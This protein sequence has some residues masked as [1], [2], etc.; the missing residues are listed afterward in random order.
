MANKIADNVTE[1]L[2]NGDLDFAADTIQILLV[3]ASFSWDP[4]TD[5]FVSDIATLGELTGAGYERKTLASKTVT[6]SAGY[7]TF[8]AASPV[9]ASIAS[10][11]TIH[12]AVVYKFDT[13][14]DASPIIAFLDVTNTPTNGQQVTFDFAATGILKLARKSGS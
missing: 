3:D 14:D 9:W 1:L 11:E 12:G 10:G 2:M 5:V 4:E 8:D 13:D 7:T 6:Q